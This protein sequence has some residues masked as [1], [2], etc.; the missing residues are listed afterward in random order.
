M[1][2][3]YRCS[4]C[5]K[6]FKIREYAKLETIHISDGAHE[7]ILDAQGKKCDSCGTTIRSHDKTFEL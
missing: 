7:E 4:K 1:A 2:M 6:R 3:V 5:N